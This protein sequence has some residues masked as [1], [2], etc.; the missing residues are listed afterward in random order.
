MDSDQHLVS[1]AM[2]GESPTGSAA[3][4]NLPVLST[5]GLA[6]YGSD[7]ED[8]DVPA[9]APAPAPRPPPPPATTATA[10]QVMHHSLQYRKNAQRNMLSFLPVYRT[11]TSTQA[12]RPFP[13][14]CVLDLSPSSL[15]SLTVLTPTCAAPP[16]L[17]RVK[18]VSS[19]ASSP[20]AGVKLAPPTT[21]T[22]GTS[23]VKQPYHRESSAS[24]PRFERGAPPAPTASTSTA[25]G[26]SSSA[27]DGVGS[28]DGPGTKLEALMLSFGAKPL[29]PNHQ[30]SVNPS[31]EVRSSPIPTPSPP[32]RLTTSST[33]LAG[34]TSQL[35]SSSP[36][37][38]PP[39][40]RFPLF[41]K[42]IS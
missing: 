29:P 21:S 10:L 4:H 1:R 6:S 27:G 26:E 23:P 34:Q 9:A 41:L 37:S 39:L 40:Q 36:H 38:K 16:S 14:A 24:P 32:S 18:G 30:D 15:R 28:T 19:R 20:L 12:H 17:G 2:Q 22:S 5:T 13:S 31:V 33:T 11:S 42:S 35:P 8:D 25:T 7:S 3:E